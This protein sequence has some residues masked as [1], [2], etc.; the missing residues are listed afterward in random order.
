MLESLSVSNFVVVEDTEMS[1]SPSLTAVVGETG[2]GKSVLVGALAAVCGLR[3][4][5]STS[6]R[7]PSKKAV[8]EAVFRIPEPVLKVR[9]ELASFSEGDGIVSLTLTI[10]PSGNVTR[11]ICGEQVSLS[12]LKRVTQCLVDIHSQRDGQAIL[13]PQGQLSALDSFG[14]ESQAG[15]LDEYSEKLAALKSA[16]RDIAELEASGRNDDLDV[17]R[18]R[19]SEIEKLHIQLDEIE[20][21]EARLEKL[22]SLEK[23]R[24]ARA[25]LSECMPGFERVSQALS[26]ALSS[27]GQI[28][29]ETGETANEAL[30]QL[31]SLERSLSDLCEG[32]QED[33]AD[34]VD[35]LNA[36]LFELDRV[37]RKYG[38]TTADI[39]DH[40][41]QFREKEALLDSYEERHAELESIRY[42]R[43]SEAERAGIKLSDSRKE[44]A[45]RLSASVCSLMESLS[46]RKGGFRIDVE[47]TD[48]LTDT[49]MDRV[50]F[51][52]D[53][54]G[55]G[56]FEPLAKAASGGESSRLMLALKCS[57][58]RA[59]PSDTLIF[60]E[61]DTG[62]SGAVAF[63]AGKL[64]RELSSSVQVICITHL[65]QV[66]CFAD[67]AL[68]V[69][70]EEV[71]G[72]VDSTSVSQ[73]DGED[74]PEAIQL[75]LE[76]GET[77]KE[78]RNAAVEL[79]RQAREAVS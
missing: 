38:P 37:R 19:I 25:S 45:E 54:I 33:D 78:A 5:Q 74:I 51:A 23:E 66:A 9:E 15:L 48:D 31:R 12:V 75:L 4:V 58:Q 79:V 62:I 3:P 18:Y 29:G 35:R 32:D 52:V 71:P 76:G 56:R 8:I 36:R 26:S 34:L 14:G 10:T 24:E 21:T 46:L 40:L 16:E 11:R 1:Y 30:D 69:S 44:L 42:K 50:S 27:F 28:P 59:N 72:A 6:L 77:S 49:G 22:S 63:A 67:R 7:D 13:T 53:L 73:Y 43:R 39:L 64:L 41:A 60:D 61:I 70:R 55:K 47:R 57:L 68:L 65:A 2:A 20:E 17:L